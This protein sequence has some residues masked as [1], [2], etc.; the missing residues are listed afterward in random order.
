[1][2]DRQLLGSVLSGLSQMEK[3]ALVPPDAMA[4]AGGP[5]MDPAMMGA[6]GPPMDPAM[7][8]MPPGVPMDPSMMGMPPGAPMDPAMAG[9]P[10]GAPMDPAMAAGGPPPADPAMM[11][12]VPAPPPAGGEGGQSMISMPVK[13]FIQ[14]LKQI[15][16]LITQAA[17]GGGD[18][19]AAG[20]AAPT[21]GAQSAEIAA[22]NAKLD[23]LMGAL[24]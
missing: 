19:T 20:P 8:G 3:S 24:G 4:G 22:M 13:D 11:G 5:P 10:P 7:M 14:F 6:G 21:G 15:F 9:M 2:I 17:K 16:A 1:M 18:A 23:A 12:Q